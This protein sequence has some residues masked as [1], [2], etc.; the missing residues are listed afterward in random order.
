MK[1]LIGSTDTNRRAGRR[2]LST[3]TAVVSLAGWNAG[4]DENLFGYVK[5]AE[6][7]PKGASEIYQWVTYRADKGAGTYRAVDWE[8]EFE[9]GVTGRFS[10][11][12]SRSRS[13]DFPRWISPVPSTGPSPGSRGFSGA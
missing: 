10:E 7:L 9:Y 13:R 6:T 11:P 8:T 3:A 4:A 2:L 5:G 12:L 1:Q